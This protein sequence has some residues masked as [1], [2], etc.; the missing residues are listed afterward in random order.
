M[1]NMRGIPE[2]S[3]GLLTMSSLPSLKTIL[4]RLPHFSDK[5]CS[6]FLDNVCQAKEAPHL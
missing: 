2:K 4:L 5:K 6:H 3:G 1:S